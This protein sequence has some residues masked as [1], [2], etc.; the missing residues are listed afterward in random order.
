MDERVHEVRSRNW[1]EII[2][3]CNSSGQTK[4]EWCRENGITLRQLYYW[5]KKLRGEL[6]EAAKG[7]ECTGLASR[8]GDSPQA[9]FAE[10]PTAPMAVA[11]ERFCADAVIR[12]GAV[13]M[14][15]SNTASRHLLESL[16][17][18][19]SNAI[20]RNGV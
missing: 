9:I 19:I 5:Q 4:A 12:V 10:I 13:T 16:G 1:A 17:R 7:K 11:E 14:E 2:M 8:I 18:V 3:A 20:Q 15:I 6:Y